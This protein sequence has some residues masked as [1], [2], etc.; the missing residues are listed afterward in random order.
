MPTYVAFLRA[1]NVGGRF[2]K[3]PT[4]RTGLADKGF[5]EVESYIQSGN[6]RFTSS[7]RSASAV[8]KVFETALEELC[9]FTVRTIVRTPVQLGELTSYG[10]GLASP[11]EEEARR[12]VTFLQKDPDDELTATLDGWDVPGERAH[13]HGREVYLWLS[14]PSHTAKL[15]NARIERR[16]A[17]ATSRDWKVVSALGQMWGV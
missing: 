16:G 15:S 4:L 12:Y 3:M 11:L 9:G 13:V 14:H 6:M 7:L 8:E 2:A 1:I 5:G 17:V 10:A